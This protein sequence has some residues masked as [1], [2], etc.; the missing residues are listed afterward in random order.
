LTL[1]SNRIHNGL[2]YT[3]NFSSHE[4]SVNKCILD[5]FYIL[6]CVALFN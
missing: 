2:I 3:I 1:S 5:K 6:K 4:S